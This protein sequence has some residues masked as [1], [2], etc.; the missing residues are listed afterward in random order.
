MDTKINVK[1][2]VSAVNQ[3]QPVLA[4][5][6]QNVAKLSGGAGASIDRA[7]RSAQ[8]HLKT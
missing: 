1:I 3:I 7:I 6:S 2:V 8:T 4:Q 5:M